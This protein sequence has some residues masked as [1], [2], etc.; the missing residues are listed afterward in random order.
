VSTDRARYREEEQPTPLLAFALGTPRTADEKG[1]QHHDAGREVEVLEKRGVGATA[2]FEVTEELAGADEKVGRYE[3][4][5]PPVVEDDAD[6]TQ[7][8]SDKKAKAV[9]PASSIEARS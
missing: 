3:D 5:D 4:P 6:E 8:L 2:R 1:H 7:E 9:V